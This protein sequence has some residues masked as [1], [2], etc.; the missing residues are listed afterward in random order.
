M[1][2]P[3]P[4]GEDTRGGLRPRRRPPASHRRLRARAV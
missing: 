1:Q 4:A 3:G 2:A